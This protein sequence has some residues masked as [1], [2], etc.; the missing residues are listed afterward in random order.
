MSIII[1]V[2]MITRNIS[3]LLILKDIQ[4]QFTVQNQNGVNVNIQGDNNIVI[5]RQ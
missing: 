4:T 1:F 5:I 3:P 2:L